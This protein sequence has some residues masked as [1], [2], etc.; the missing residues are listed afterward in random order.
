V[1]REFLGVTNAFA[2]LGLAPRPWLAPAEIKT[3]YHDLARERAPLASLNEAR[4]ILESPAARLRHLASL[5]APEMT[6]FQKPSP[7]WAIFETIGNFCKDVREWRKRQGTTALERS[8]QLA[9]AGRLRSQLLAARDLLESDHARLEA[10]TLSLDAG[11]PQVNAAA[12]LTLAEEWTFWSRWND[13]LHESA[14]L[15]DGA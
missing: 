6:E 12:L 11:W 5:V 7:N 3:R 2:E 4:R 9:A 14:A 1:R 10:L 8:V 13:A 15:L